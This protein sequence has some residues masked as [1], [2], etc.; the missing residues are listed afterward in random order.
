MRKYHLLFLLGLLSSLTY[1]QS[2]S[3]SEALNKALKFFNPAQKVK[4]RV[5]GITT[6]Q[7]AYKSATADKT[8]YY[9]FN[10][11]EGGYVIIGGDE[12]ACEILGYSHEGTFDYARIPENMKW[13]L[14]QYDSEIDY[15]IDMVRSGKAS[16]AKRS[17]KLG[18]PGTSASISPLLG[19]GIDAIRWD[20]SN[21]YNL[22]ID[23]G[24]GYF[25]TGCTTTA[26]AQVMKFHE[27]PSQDTGIRYDQKLLGTVNGTPLYAPA[28][29]EDYTYNWGSMKRQ[30]SR[31]NYSLADTEA[32]DVANLCY[33]VSRSIDAKYGT[34]STSASVRTLGQKLVDH[35]KYDK[36][37]TFRQ[38]E[39]YSDAQWEAI[40]RDELSAHRPVVYAGQDVNGGGGHAFVCDGYDAASD[41]YHFNWG[42]SGYCDAYFVVT[43]TNALMPHGS[44]S[45][46]A[47]QNAAYSGNQEILTGVQPDKGGDYPCIIATPGYT[48]STPQLNYGKAVVINGKL[49]NATY[50]DYKNKLGLLFVNVED[51]TDKVVAIGGVANLPP[52]YF[53]SSFNVN[54]P[55]T[56]KEGGCYYVIP[57]FEDNAGQW[58]KCHMPDD[59]EVPVL[60]VLEADRSTRARCSEWTLPV[61]EL[62]LGSSTVTSSGKF[63]NAGDFEATI[64]FGFKFTNVS[65][66]TDFAYSTSRTQT[67]G[68]G[69]YTYNMPLTVPTRL[70]VGSTYRVTAVYLSTGGDWLECDKTSEFSDPTLLITPATNLILTEEPT[71]KNGGYATESDCYI[72]FKVKNPTSEQLTK[73]LV[74]WVGN[75]SG[76]GAYYPSVTFAPGEEKSFDCRKA[77]KGRAHDT[78]SVRIVN[79]SDNQQFYATALTL[80][81]ELPV[82]FTM[83]PAHWGTLCLPYDAEV[84]AGLTAYTVTDTDGSMLVKEEANILEMNHPYLISGAEGTYNFVGPHTPS[85][86]Y[87]SGLLYGVTTVPESGE[88]IYA[89]ADSYVLQKQSSGLGFYRVETTQKIR[90]Y[91]AYLS[92]PNAANATARFIIDEGTTGLDAAATSLRHS[93]IYN[94]QGQRVQSGTKG[95]VIERGKL[96]FEK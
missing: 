67:L 10:N 2:V 5:G 64:T 60:T 49:Q 41:T 66:E 63:G 48:L 58:Q 39:Y 86:T 34:S 25:Y 70:T 3:E 93:T 51:A 11:A 87:C 77:M 69:Y 40:L 91:S 21:P 80:V 75:E 78:Y 94:L 85:G 59:F 56:L 18:A 24:K 55:E 81:D 65:D 16:I 36:S 53:Y 23:G 79:Y 88:D 92:L 30:Y 20:Q 8:R 28:I 83:T 89:P 57:V 95:L 9:V 22:A 13:W 84:P 15:A 31:H 35:F 6:M 17:K 76:N 54:M 12:A 27:H 61:N 47:G 38:R 42:W 37:L 43:G 33:R 14:N 72:T 44:G 52:Y 96:K 4:N 32:K 90:P 46:G 74:V 68:K 62:A 50:T 82:A 26:A 45:G 73:D 1:A 29:T 7:L 19:E 71:I